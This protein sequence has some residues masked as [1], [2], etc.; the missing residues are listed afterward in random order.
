MMECW[1]LS[2]CVPIYLFGHHLH[3][4][5]MG[6][7]TYLLAV[8]SNFL[9]SQQYESRLAYSVSGLPECLIWCHC[10]GMI[11]D[12]HLRVIHPGFAFGPACRQSSCHA[13]DSHLFLQLTS[14]YRCAS[15]TMYSS[16]ATHCAFLLSACQSSAH[17][18]HRGCAI[19]SAS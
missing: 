4:G 10:V 2:R 1:R 14:F 12:R 11:D 9:A 3:G 19:G 5:E 13:E 8:E 18:L 6:L 15:Q 16:I 7:P 17:V